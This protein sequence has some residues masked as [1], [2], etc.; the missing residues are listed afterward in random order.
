MSKI[1][2]L[3]FVHIPKT[4]GR[5]ITRTGK[6]NNLKWGYYY[7]KTQNINLWH[8]PYIMH[9]YPANPANCFAVIRNP[10]ERIISAYKFKFKKSYSIEHLNR[11]VLLELIEM[12]NLLFDISNNID[13]LKKK[14]T[15]HLLPQHYFTHDLNY[16]QVVDNLIQFDNLK[17]E[18]ETLMEKYDSDIKLQ[19]HIGKAS[20]DEYTENSLS[21]ENVLLI[22]SI[23]RKDF[24][25]YNFEMLH[26][27][28]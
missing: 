4:G 17:E 14:L 19:I 15:I 20:D 13:K 25:L 16:N 9:K 11:W 5:S 10:Y 24:E 18:F 26:T 21:I 1:D 27:D 8:V 2:E 3:F 23:Y 6:S 28:K 22:N 7:W 12:N